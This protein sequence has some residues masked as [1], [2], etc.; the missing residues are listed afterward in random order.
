MSVI[1]IAIDYHNLVPKR[2]KGKQ[3]INQNRNKHKSQHK[4][5]QNSLNPLR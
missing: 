5:F 1:T 2:N 4:L 3:N